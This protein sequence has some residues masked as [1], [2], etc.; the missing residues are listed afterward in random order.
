MNKAF[1]VYI[2]IP[3]CKRKCPYCDFNVH[4]M[5]PVPESTY[6]EALL[7]E[8]NNKSEEAEW[9]QRHIQSIYFGGG[10][11]SLMSADFYSRVLEQLR[12]AFPWIAGLEICMEANP[13]ELPLSY[14]EDLKKIG[15]NRLS[16]GVQ[17]FFE[18]SL[19][20]LGRRHTPVEVSQ[21]FQAARSAG[22]NNINLDLIYGNPGQTFEE[23]ASDLNQGLL[24]QPEHFSLYGLGIE[25]G[26]P[27][28]RDLKNGW[29]NLPP[30]EEAAAMMELGREL[31]SS[32]GYVHYEISNYAKP[33]KESKH[34]LAYW[35][36]DDYLGFGAG[37]HSF[38]RQCPGSKGIF[39]ERWSNYTEPL[40]YISSIINNGQALCWKEKLDESS[41][42]FEFFFLGLR[43]M[44][45]VACEDYQ[46]LFNRD[47]QKD[48]G[49]LLERLKTGE[50]IKGEGGRICLSNTGVLLAD[51]VISE[52]A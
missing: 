2:H 36:G 28:Y 14:L 7:K 34:N 21:S 37:A 26:T 15:L 27:F 52:F 38:I 43:K 45:G 17:S 42:R 22:F 51:S 47:L 4:V 12:W 18:T 10:T 20:V 29:L 41:A 19:K 1:S 11:P 46:M 25:H 30:E 50:L 31:L 3:F 5:R 49:P 48:Y 32:K 16:L 8:I 24:L 23:W 6:L 40:K 35:N 33:G 39:G 9:G 44:R 13:E